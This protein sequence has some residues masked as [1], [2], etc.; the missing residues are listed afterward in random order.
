MSEIRLEKSESPVP[1]Y[2]I[3]SILVNGEH[4]KGMFRVPLA[5]VEDPVALAVNRGKKATNMAGGIEVKVLSNCMTRG[6]ILE[7]D[8]PFTADNVIKYIEQEGNGGLRQAVESGTRYGRLL[9]IECQTM[10]DDIYL[11]LSMSCGDAA[12]HN[13]TTLAAVRLA[14][15]ITSR[16]PG[17]VTLLSASSNTC[18][19]KKPAAINVEK[20]RGKH[21]VASARIP[22]DT[23]RK[24]LK[25]EP[26]R[27]ARL[28]YKKNFV[29]SRLA[30]AL[31][32]NNSN[33]ANML[34]AVY[35]ATGQDAANVVEGSMGTTTAKLMQDGSLE[36]MVDIPCVIVGT[37]GGG[38]SNPYAK[39]HLEM[40]QCYG[41]GDPLGSNGLKLAEIIGATVLAGELNTLA[42]LAD[43]RKHAECHAKYE[44][45]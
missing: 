27:L 6:I 41:G 34:A 16:F 22:A 13:M 14:E 9:S 45:R 12:G 23:V 10:R 19:D 40:M 11:R 28:N 31:Y 36:F 44:R 8:S 20:G 21:V 15:Y 2:I 38:T 24:I 17:K 42:S 1:T 43:G 5:T 33:Y 7:T 39:R 37:V 3:D 4:A 30:D 32:G 35:I 18:S 26:E 25:V 29:G